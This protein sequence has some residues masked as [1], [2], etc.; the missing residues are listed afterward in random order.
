MCDKRKYYSVYI[1]ITSQRVLITTGVHNAKKVV[2]R[3]VKEIPV[4][5]RM[6]VVTVNISNL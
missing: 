2:P 5:K 3:T 4:T 1:C 6:D